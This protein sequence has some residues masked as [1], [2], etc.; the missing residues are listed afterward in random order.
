MDSILEAKIRDGFIKEDVPERLLS[1]I[2]MDMTSVEKE[3]IYTRFLQSVFEKITNMPWV[4]IV[5]PFAF[6]VLPL[7]F[8]N[9]FGPG[10]SSMDEI[11]TYA[12]TDHMGNLSMAYAAENTQDVSGWFENEMGF[13]IAVPDMSGQG[14]KLKGGRKCHFGKCDVAYLFYK[15][16]DR[17]ISLFIINSDDVK[18]DMGKNGTYLMNYNEC[19]VK[20]WKTAD[21]FY[22]M[23]E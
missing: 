2:E 8:V 11:G 16:E 1:R 9:P 4:K 14:L 19:T 23:V 5:P 6:A 20:I 18:F 15:K 7:L 3:G 17:R 21:L 13:K 12:A 22:A 10:F